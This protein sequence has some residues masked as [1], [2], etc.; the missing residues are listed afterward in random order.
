MQVPGTSP[1]LQGSAGARQVGQGLPR[2]RVHHGGD[3][4]GLT[5]LEKGVGKA[6]L[7]S[8]GEVEGWTATYHS[9]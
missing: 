7:P 2:Q 5:P 6:L 3:S 8:R 4:R 1:S 9:E